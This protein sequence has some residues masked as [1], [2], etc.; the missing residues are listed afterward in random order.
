MVR[1]E[2][3]H[4][5]FLNWLGMEARCKVAQHSTGWMAGAFAECVRTKQLV[6]THFSARYYDTSRPV[7]GDWR[8]RPPDMEAE[9]EAAARSVGALVQEARQYYA[10]RVRAASDFC[11]F[12]V[13][14]L[15]DGNS[16]RSGNN[17]GLEEDSV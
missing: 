9:A 5:M 1:S 11:T 17:G 3:N 8:P 13:P 10:G 2:W 12:Q 7:N 14:P 6:L 4:Y 16:D 15:R